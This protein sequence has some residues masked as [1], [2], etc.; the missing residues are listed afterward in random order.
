[1]RSGQFLEIDEAG[2]VECQ[3]L[4]ASGCFMSFSENSD[5]T[6]RSSPRLYLARARFSISSTRAFDLSTARLQARELA[7]HVMADRAD[8]H[9]ARRGVHLDGPRVARPPTGTAAAWPLCCCRPLLV[10]AR[11][12]RPAAA[13]RLPRPPPR[14][15]PSAQRPT[16]PSPMPLSVLLC[17]MCRNQFQSREKNRHGLLQRHSRQRNSA[18]DGRLFP[19]TL[20]SPTSRKKRTQA[21]AKRTEAHLTAPNRTE[22]AGKRT[23]FSPAPRRQ[24]RTYNIT[25]TKNG[26]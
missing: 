2:A 3:G 13:H 21:A 1:M 16:S 7:V 15:S 18:S 11:H 19:A 25:A 9:L 8:D 26:F 4:L 6:T 22:P 5:S 17:S 23:H 14:T 20:S 12:T 10:P 24:F